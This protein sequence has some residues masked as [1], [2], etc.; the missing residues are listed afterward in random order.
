MGANV[1]DNASEQADR[2]AAEYRKIQ[3]AVD[4]KPKSKESKGAIR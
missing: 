1:A 2:T 3:Q 4:D